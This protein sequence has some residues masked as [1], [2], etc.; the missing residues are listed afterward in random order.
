MKPTKAVIV[1]TWMVDHLTFG[2]TNQALSGDLLE[3]MESGRSIAWY[4]RQVGSAVTT[5]LVRK[6][7]ELIIPLI[8]CAV[9]TLF[10]P[11][12]ALLSKVVLVRA[13]PA[14]LTDFAW[15]E[16]ALVAICYGIVPAL[17]FV[18]LGFLV[19]VLLRIKTFHELNAQRVLWAASAS[20]NVL[21]V[22]TQ[23]LLW[24]FRRSRIDL[25]SLMRPDFYSSFHLLSI[26]IPLALSLLGALVFARSRVHR[27]G[28]R[29]RQ[30]D[31]Q[32]V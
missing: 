8:Y 16:S 6:L 31:F 10:Y 1:G 25:D 11:S 12:W 3:E 17:A 9:W 28:G 23:L 29:G 4:W 7:S 30:H 18:W 15:P 27:R 19:Y 14:G 13:V 20:L 32:S 2:L 21:L 22:S 5:G 26:S 24:H